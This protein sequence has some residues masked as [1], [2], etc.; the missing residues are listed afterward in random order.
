MYTHPETRKLVGTLFPIVGVLLLIGA[1]VAAVTTDRFIRSATRAEGE[2]IRLNAGGAHP[3]IRFVPQGEASVQFS[4]QGLIKYAVGDRVTVLYRKDSQSPP[5]Y[6]TQIDTP[7][8]LWAT[9]ALL[10]WLGGGFVIG[11]LYTKSR[12]V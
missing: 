6:Q 7:G 8:A 1:I 9:T 2:V 12:D 5:G 3:E 4:G 10:T 11:G